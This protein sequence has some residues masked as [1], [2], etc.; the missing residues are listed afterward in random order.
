VTANR[1]GKTKLIRKIIDLFSLKV[2]FTLFFIIFVAAIGI[3]VIVT[4]QRQIRD[5]TNLVGTQLG[6]PIALRASAFIDGDRFERFCENPDENDPYY[7]EIRVKLYDLKQETNCLYLYTMAPYKENT[8]RFIIDGSGLPGEPA[9]SP[10]GSEEDIND[11]DQAY[12]DA[13]TTGEPQIGF[14]DTQGSWGT[15]IGTYA[16]IINSR[17][18]VVGIVGCD[19]DAEEINRQLQDRHRQQIILSLLFIAIGLVV[20]V[21]LANSIT[22]QNR[23]LRELNKKANAASDAKSS[24]LARTSH[25]IRTPMNAILGMTELLLREDISDNAH[26]YAISIKQAGSNLVSIIND[27]LDFSK[28]ES[29]KVDIVPAEYLLASVI[30]DCISIVRMKVEE[31]NLDFRA[32][33]DSGLP[34]GLVGDVA[35]V[36]QIL[37]N[38]LTNAVKYTTEGSVSLKVAGRSY[39]QKAINLQF[40]VSDTGIG[41]RPE[42]M[43]KLFGDFTRFDLT[44]N[45]GVEGT[46]LGL[47]ISRSL[48]RLMG[49]DIIVKSVYREGSTFTAIIPQETSNSEPIGNLWG[50]ELQAPVREKSCVCFIAPEARLLIVDDIKTNLKVAEGLLSLYQT[51]IS[52][53]MSGVEAINLVKKNH[54]DLIFMDHM[55]PG[56]DGME[57]VR[58]IREWE[59]EQKKTEPER[60]PIAIVALTANAMSGMKELF[61]QNEFDDYLSKPIEITKLDECIKKWISKEKQTVPEAPLKRKAEKAGSFLRGIEGL[62]A[63]RGMAMTGGTAAGYRAVLSSFV[64]DAAKRLERFDLSGDEYN[65]ED[66]T[67]QVHA[68]KSASATIGAI[69]LSARAV[70]LEAAGG[71]KDM[72]FVK[73]RLPEFYRL[74]SELVHQI[75][76]GL[77]KEFADHAGG[78]AERLTGDQIAGL[79]DALRRKDIEAIDRLLNEYG[80]RALDADTLEKLAAVSDAVLMSEFEDALDILP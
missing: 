32:D 14:I 76:E 4:S 2:R 24:F 26:K 27:I 19:Y 18:T 40:E 50:K 10:L 69:E 45:Q 38:L 79:N 8:H 25:E 56:M 22:L 9:F 41:I 13:Y 62:D 61:L 1:F 46:G 57:A 80:H 11:Y 29:G 74:L 35:R 3:V 72:A 6:L 78:G 44:Q 71:K 75:D 73:S 64:K 58:H 43:D 15:L 7:E 12:F 20:F 67:I 36:R 23:Q 68:L 59:R 5:I 65:L 70:A 42:D 17:G 39:G 31:K 34:S 55:M 52:T 21:S 30:N 54:Y 51:N 37:L 47:A 60:K 28:I 48:C 16:P 49:G 66:L 53:A 77:K 33:V 63:Q